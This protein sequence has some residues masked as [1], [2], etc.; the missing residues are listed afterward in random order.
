MKTKNYLKK[1]QV[2]AIKAIATFVLF[3]L[4]VFITFS[5]YDLYT[6]KDVNY[7]KFLYCVLSEEYYLFSKTVFPLVAL[8]LCFSIIAGVIQSRNKLLARSLIGAL[9]LFIGVYLWGE[10]LMSTATAC[11]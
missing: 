4:A 5:S 2:Y 6:G 10:W 8:F 9:L 1:W 3:V 11:I 7:N